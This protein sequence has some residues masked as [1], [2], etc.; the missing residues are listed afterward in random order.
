MSRQSPKPIVAPFPTIDRI[1][2]ERKLLQI[3]ISFSQQSH[4]EYSRSGR[5]QSRHSLG[6][7]RERMMRRVDDDHRQTDDIHPKSLERIKHA[8][9]H[10]VALPVFELFIPADQH[11]PVHQITGEPNSP[12]THQYR[13]HQLSAVVRLGLTASLAQEKRHERND[14]EVDASGEISEL[15]ALKSGGDH[16]KDH[17]HHACDHGTDG[18]IVLIEQRYHFERW[19]VISGATSLRNAAD[20]LC[21]WGVGRGI[22]PGG[23]IDQSLPI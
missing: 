7:F 5:I 9:P 15:V 10:N 20:R 18:Q 23:S 14:D 1:L 19:R 2:P 22:F 13:D 17:L 4:K 3:R 8:E 16:E 6:S 12:Q 21:A 11:D